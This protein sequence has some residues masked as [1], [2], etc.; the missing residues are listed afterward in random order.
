MPSVITEGRYTAEFLASE[1]NGA[2]S[3]E[4]VTLL[5]GQNLKAGAVLGKVTADGKYKEWNPGNVDGSE[6]AVAVL[7]ANVDATD[8]DKRAVIIARDAEVNGN[9]LEYF[10]GASAANKTAAA[11]QLAAVGII[12]R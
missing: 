10:T 9:A 6:T 1:A 7:Y 4:Q 5:T 11:T 8:G 12:V 2:R 3:R